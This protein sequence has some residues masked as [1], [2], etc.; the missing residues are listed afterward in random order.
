MLCMQAT[1]KGRPHKGPR[2]L[3][4]GRV[5]EPLADELVEEIQDFGLT[6]TDFLAS[7][8]E[9]YMSPA[10]DPLREKLRA[11]NQNRTQQ[12]LPLKDRMKT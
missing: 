9:Y 1:R 6:T 10:G 4:A 5:P 8:V 12:E 11:A 3:L 2:K 7:L